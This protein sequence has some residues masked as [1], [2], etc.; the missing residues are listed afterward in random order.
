MAYCKWCSREHNETSDR[1][2]LCPMCSKRWRGKKNF[3]DIKELGLTKDDPGDEEY[4]ALVHMNTCQFAQEVMDRRI[5]RMKYEIEATW[6]DKVRERRAV[7]KKKQC[8][9]LLKYNTYQMRKYS[10]YRST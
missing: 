6:D 10:M 3:I 7:A 2:D 9:V 5:A 1:K 8:Y 4:R